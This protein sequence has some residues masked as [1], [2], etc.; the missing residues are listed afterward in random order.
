MSHR[1]MTVEIES[2]DGEPIDME[3]VDAALRAIGVKAKGWA[4]GCHIL[5]RGA[6]DDLLRRL[7]TAKHLLTPTK[8]DDEG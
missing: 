5:A 8:G 3:A 6:L 1:V 7:D 4:P 2:T